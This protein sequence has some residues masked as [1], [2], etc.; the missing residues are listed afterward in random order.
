MTDDLPSRGTCNTPS[1]PRISDHYGLGQ[2]TLETDLIVSVL[3]YHKPTEAAT[4]GVL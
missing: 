3:F 4:G 1:F 2:N